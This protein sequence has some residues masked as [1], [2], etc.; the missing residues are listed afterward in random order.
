MNS[1]LKILIRNDHEQERIFFPNRFTE[2][3]MNKNILLLKIYEQNKNI[4][5]GSRADPWWGLWLRSFK[6][7][8]ILLL[9]ILEFEFIW[10]NS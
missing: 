4:K 6:I 10:L 5:T 8:Y 1:F 3:N 9:E 7:I 2:P